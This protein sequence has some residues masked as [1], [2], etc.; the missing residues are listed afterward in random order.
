[1]RRSSSDPSLTTTFPQPTSRP[2]LPPLLQNLRRNGHTLRRRRPTPPPQTTRPSS[3]PQ[4]PPSTFGDYVRAEMKSSQTTSVHL[5]DAQL[6]ATDGPHLLPFARRNLKLDFLQIEAGG[7][8]INRVATRLEILSEVRQNWDAPPNPGRHR[9]VRHSTTHRRRDDTAADFRAA[10]R[11]GRN[12][13]QMRTA[14]RADRPRRPMPRTPGLEHR[15]PANRL[16]V[17]D[18]R[19]IDPA[20]TPKPAIWVREDA[21]LVSLESVRAIILH[22]KIFVFNPDHEK[23]QATIWY[24]RKR[25]LNHRED[26]FMPF[27]FVALEAILIN[28]CLVLEGEFHAIEPELRLTLGDLPKIINSEQL[29]RLRQLEQRLNYYYSRARKVQHALQTVLDEDE[30]MADMYLTEKRRNPGVTRNPVDH[31]EAEM[32]LET[33]LQNVDDLTSKAGLLNRAIDDTENLIEIHLDTM[34]NRLLLV[35]LIITVIT[36]ILSFGTMVTSMFGMNFPLPNAMQTLPQSQFYFGGTVGLMLLTMTVALIVLTRWCK[37]Q[38]IYS[39]TGRTIVGR[40]RR[41]K[42]GVVAKA[43]EDTRRQAEALL[44]KPHRPVPR[45]RSTDVSVDEW[46]ELPR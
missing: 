11:R 42:T 1:M 20:F 45:A 35:D 23:S 6:L 22:N 17:R 10:A 19:Q 3:Q 32:L 26:I 34:Q 21:L 5:P 7:D 2:F 4:P 30:D 15:P 9:P 31:D 16:T 29:E 18:M 27:E 36:T 24:I 25:L 44:N 14:P 33:Y 39:Y 37:R 12:G 13:R 43:S 8:C 28:T 38:G 46:P 41:S 40:K